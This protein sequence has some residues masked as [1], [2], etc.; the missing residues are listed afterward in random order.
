LGIG[1]DKTQENKSE[2]SPH[3]VYRKIEG[4]LFD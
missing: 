4:K 2:A 3:R 1:A